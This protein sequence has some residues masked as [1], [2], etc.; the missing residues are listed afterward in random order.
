MKFTNA[1]ILAAVLTLAVTGSFASAGS[2]TGSLA[3]SATVTGNCTVTGSTLAFGAYDYA[4]TNRTANVDQTS[5]VTLLCTSGTVGTV[6]LGQG[7]NAGTGSTD[8]VPARRLVSGTDFLNYALFSDS[9]GGTVWGNT[10][11][12]G[13]VNAAGTGANQTLT[14]YGR[15]AGGQNVPVGNYTDTVIVTVDF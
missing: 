1:R 3:P 5:L 12:T 8:A 7:A 11:A 15:V 14:V 10:T 2:N 13:K 4:V 9:P 6:R